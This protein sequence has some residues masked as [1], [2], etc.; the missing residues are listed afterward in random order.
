MQIKTTMSDHL[1]P[2]WKTKR[3][4]P[5]CHQWGCEKTNTPITGKHVEKGGPSRHQWECK[6]VQPLQRTVQRFLRKI[7]NRNYHVI[8]HPTAESLSKRNEIT[9]LK[10]Y[11][12]PHVHCSD[13]YN[14]QDKETTYVSSDEWMDKENA[15]HIHTHKY[16]T[17]W[18]I[19]QP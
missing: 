16:Y 2:K 9:V 10:R 15:V 11:L 6:L 12:Y 4:G 18:N 7:K 13:I 14:S 17:Q 3:R 19:I 1:I 8:Q 5:L